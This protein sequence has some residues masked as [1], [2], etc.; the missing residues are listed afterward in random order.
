MAGA[1]AMAGTGGAAG[2][3]G[4]VSGSQ[5]GQDGGSGSASDSAGMMG[6]SC[7]ECEQMSCRMIAG[8]A[9]PDYYAGCYE[10]QGSAA[11]GRAKGTA[12]SALCEAAATCI[13]ASKCINF[14]T[15]EPER[16]YCGSANRVSCLQGKGIDGPCQ[17]E[18]ENAAETNKPDEIF[19]RFFDIST[20]LAIAG[21][22]TLVMFCDYRQC[23]S[24]CLGLP[25]PDGGAMP[26]PVD[27]A[28]GGPDAG[29]KLDSGGGLKSD[30]AVDA[31]AG[32]TPDAATPG[33]DAPGTEQPLTYQMCRQC[34]GKGFACE[35]VLTGCDL[36]GTMA[37]GPAQGRSK[38]EVCE[39]LLSCWRSTGCYYDPQATTPF[40][41]AARCYCGTTDPLGCLSEG[42]AN[43]PCKAQT[44]A[45]AGSTDPIVAAGAAA[46]S[47]TVLGSLT[48]NQQCGAEVCG[49]VCIYG[50]PPGTG[51][52]GQGGTGGSGGSSGA[53]GSGGSAGGAGG[54]GGSSG[55]GAGGGAGGSGGGTGSGGGGEGGG[56]GAGGASGS[57]SGGS[58][59]AGS[60]S[61]GTS[62]G[63]NPIVVGPEC[64]ACEAEKCRDLGIDIYAA[65]FEAEGNAA[66]G[67][68]AGRPRRELCVEMLECMRSSGCARADDPSEVN[69]AC[70]CGTFTNEQCLTGKADGPCKSQ[71][72]AAGES[73]VGSTILTNRLS[74]PPYASSAAANLMAYCDK[75]VCADVCSG[76]TGGGGAGGAG[77]NAGS[78]G[79]GGASGSGGVGG[80]AGAGASGSGGGGSGGTAAGGGSGGTAGTGSGGAVAAG[81]GGGGSGGPGGNL[82]SNGGFN[83]DIAGWASEITTTLGWEGSRD[84]GGASGSGSLSVTNVSVAEADGSTMG[85]ARQCVAISGQTGF[86]I[87]AQV[88]IPTGQGSGAGALNLQFFPSADCTGSNIGAHTT[89][90]FSTTGGSWRELKGISG[91]PPGAQSILVRPVSIKPFRA[92]PFRVLFDNI[93]LEPLF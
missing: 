33:P 18:I 6:P 72:Q 93:A 58:G 60:G 57:G 90:S 2:G 47:T 43:G 63:G 45:A 66:E 28:P 19:T 76:T 11:D 71:I 10:L 15:A 75:T 36:E 68:A 39:D 92:Q 86:W 34:M 8:G 17:K 82:L 31:P 61:G 44:E 74:E 64:K 3:A 87:R 69:R 29:A 88:F 77:G 84:S 1:G 13:R 65:C 32:Q 9:E 55:G 56:S 73:T 70:Y 67:P 62:G 14:E 5:M 59:G 23:G 38:K 4:G 40:D 51:G 52:G 41:P 50:D 42:A 16:C 78:G 7:R 80:S 54:A 53:A 81:T 21:A 46:D 91:K 85:G 25:P 37:E 20:G 27:T 49:E 48:Q 12:R 24:A 89:A 22:T 35:N 26:P 79:S 83:Q 30:A